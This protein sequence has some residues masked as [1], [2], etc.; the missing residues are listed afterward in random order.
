MGFAPGLPNSPQ[1]HEQVCYLKE[2]RRHDDK[3]QAVHQE[4][5]EVQAGA[6]EVF[7]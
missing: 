3:P 2:R 5:I 7:F 1:L 4:E 6:G